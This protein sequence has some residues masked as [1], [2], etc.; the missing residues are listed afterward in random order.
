MLFVRYFDDV[1]QYVV[2]NEAGDCLIVTSSSAIAEFVES[3][4]KGVP[5]ELRLN[6]GGDPGTKTE[7]KLWHHVRKY[8]KHR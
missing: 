1:A 7:H 6:V 5:R 8:S 2:C 3:H 4:I